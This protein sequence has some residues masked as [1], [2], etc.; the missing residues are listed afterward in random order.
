M[1]INNVVHRPTNKKKMTKLVEELSSVILL[2]A[3][4][5]KAQLGEQV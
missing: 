1:A 5:L 3:V 2:L 4:G